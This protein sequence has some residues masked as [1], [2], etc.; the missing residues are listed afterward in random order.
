MSRKIH[1]TINNNK[2]NNSKD[3]KF[4]H[5]QVENKGL[6]RLQRHGIFI[7][8]HKYDNQIIHK[9]KNMAKRNQLSHMSHKPINGKEKGKFS[10]HEPYKLSA[11]KT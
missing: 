8:N 7:H 3:T 2:I 11:D 6:Y 10:I 4:V 5:I 1:T 9:L